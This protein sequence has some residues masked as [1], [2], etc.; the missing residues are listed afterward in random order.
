MASCLGTDAECFLHD[1]FLK[2]CLVVD[3]KFT[4]YECPVGIFYTELF[5]AQIFDLINACIGIIIDGDAVI[6]PEFGRKAVI[7]PSIGVVLT[8]INIY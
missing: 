1:I 4:R 3:L 6:D 7:V 8:A 2:L 5:R